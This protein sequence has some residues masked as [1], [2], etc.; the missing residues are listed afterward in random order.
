MKDNTGG[1]TWKHILM[2]TWVI[3]T[4][5]AVIIYVISRDVCATASD[6]ISGV[7]SAA[8]SHHFSVRSFKI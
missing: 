1:F 8:V 3:I 5:S 4:I 2:H 6:Y 7:G